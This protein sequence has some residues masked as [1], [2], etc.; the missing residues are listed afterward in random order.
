MHQYTKT[1]DQ[2]EIVHYVRVTDVHLLEELRGFFVVAVEVFAFQLHPVESVYGVQQTVEART[3]VRYVEH[4]AE[5]V[6]RVHIANAE[7]KDG[8]QHRDYGTDEYRDLQKSSFNSELL[9]LHLK[10]II[11]VDRISFIYAF[12][13]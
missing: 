2:Y 13:Q 5:H 4:P 11:H 9:C 8:E 3:K 10:L 6:R 7:T 12:M 1:K